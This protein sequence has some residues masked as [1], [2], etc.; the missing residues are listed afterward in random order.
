MNKTHQIETLSGMNPRTAH[1]LF[2]KLS[3]EFSGISWDGFRSWADA[4]SF[5]ERIRHRE[6]PRRSIQPVRP[7]QNCLRES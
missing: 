1:K 7:E 6:K 5:F 3:A 2:R 4:I